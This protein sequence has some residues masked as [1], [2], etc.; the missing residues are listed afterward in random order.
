MK[1]ARVDILSAEILNTADAICFTSNGVVKSNGEL[2][3]GA[4]VAKAFAD[5]YPGASFYFGQ[6][7]SKVGNKLF[8]MDNKPMVV[9]F[10]T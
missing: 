3:M 9:S 7:V 2:V 1:E 5:K 4:G 8:A 6:W 10:P